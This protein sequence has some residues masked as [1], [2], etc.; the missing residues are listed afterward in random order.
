MVE[1][2]LGQRVFELGVS[3]LV[4][5]IVGALLVFSW[6]LPTEWQGIIVLIPIAFSFVMLISDLEKTVL[7]G[8]AISVPLNLDRSLMISP[9][10]R[11]PENIAQGHRTIVALTELR[12]SL[13]FLL[14][15]I[16]YALWLVRTPGS[17]RKPI[18]FFAG[19]SVPALGL[20][21]FS[22]LSMFRAQ[23]LQ[24]SLF[25][26]VQLVELFL[27]Y[28]YLANHVR[29]SQRLLTFVSV[30]MWAMLAESVLMIWQ[31]ITGATFSV[32]GIHAMVLENPLRVGGTLMHPNVAGGII[33]AH[34]ALVCT[35]ICIS[36][37]RSQR[38]F[39]V[40]CFVVGCIAAITTGSRAS[41]GSLVVALLAFG[42]IGA[43]RGWVRRDALMLLFIATFAIAGVFYPAIRT[44]LTT[45][46]RGSAQ[47]RPMMARLAWNVIQAHPWLGVGVNNYA[48]VARDY[49]TPDVG[50]LDDVLRYVIDQ[51]VHNRY[52]L[53]WAEIGLFGLLMYLSFLLAPLVQAW[54]HIKSDDRFRSLMAL[55]L[56]CAIASMSIQMLVEHFS[57]RPSAIFVWLLV[58]LVASLRNLELDGVEPLASAQV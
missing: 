44:R 1:T 35:V 54:N 11:N 29:T 49:Y 31:W 23:D 27:V 51:A 47:S 10:S 17:D 57:P 28:F 39:A 34:L 13:V 46:D 32:A 16:G 4:G 48:L 3:L 43:W 58:S 9:Y 40:I 52:L 21:F 15:L 2:G 56:G 14:L 20:A 24:L 26:I 36:P 30:L 33:S 37:K 19:T 25:R 38:G 8:I 18:R 42:L 6:G 50:E 7:A 53:I 41:W 45:W 12:L 55:G 5:L 22:L